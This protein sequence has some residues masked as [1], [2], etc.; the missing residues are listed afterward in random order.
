MTGVSGIETI[1]EMSAIDS[2]ILFKL[3][4]IIVPGIATFFVS[5][6]F[7]AIGHQNVKKTE[8]FDDAF[9]QVQTFSGKVMIVL[10]YFSIFL[11]GL[12]LLRI[13]IGQ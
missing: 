7:R 9:S 5:K 11:Y 1:D 10:S 2:P 4:I 8:Q 12:W 3:F 6:R 13:F